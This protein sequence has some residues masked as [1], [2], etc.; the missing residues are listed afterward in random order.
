MTG[1]GAGAGG[2]TTTG[3]GSGT[4]SGT[5]AGA[6]IGLG[7]QEGSVRQVQLGILSSTVM[8]GNPPALTGAIAG[9]L[10]SLILASIVKADKPP[11]LSSACTAVT[12]AIII[13]I[14]TNIPIFFII[15]PFRPNFNKLTF[16]KNNSHL[17]HIFFPWMIF[18]IIK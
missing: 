8:A 18:L 6:T 14:N 7:Q 5:G 13:I 2:G 17:K 3:A 1:L 4:G 10:P 16:W 11:A 9:A 12:I 15:P